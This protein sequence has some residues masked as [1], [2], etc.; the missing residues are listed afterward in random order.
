MLHH[1]IIDPFL[2][3]FLLVLPSLAWRQLN[4]WTQEVSVAPQPVTPPATPA[5]PSASPKALPKVAP[6]APQPAKPAAPALS[7]AELIRNQAS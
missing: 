4:A 2:F 3:S 6:R 5:K 1:L 7:L